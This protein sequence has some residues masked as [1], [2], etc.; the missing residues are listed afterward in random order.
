MMMMRL[1][2][3]G[4]HSPSTMS[5]LQMYHTTRISFAVKLPNRVS[6]DE[7]PFDQVKLHL[8]AF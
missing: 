3:H 7:T 5:F 1:L 4:L 2:L 6:L 8:A